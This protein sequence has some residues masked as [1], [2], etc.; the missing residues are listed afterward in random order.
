[1]MG[2][3]PLTRGKLSRRAR[4]LLS[5][6][7][8]PAH[9]GKTPHASRSP[10]RAAAHPRS[11]GENS[12][13]FKTSSCNAGSSPLT[14]GKPGHSPGSPRRCRLIP[15]HAGKTHPQYSKAR[16]QPGSSPLTRGKPCGQIPQQE[17]AGLIPAHAG[18]TTPGDRTRLCHRAHPRSRGENE[19]TVDKEIESKGS[20]P[21]TRGKP[22]CVALAGR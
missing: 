7:L 2:S 1:M 14:R 15:A 5:P 3:S 22:G 4:R 13:V 18:K 10:E 11:R 9:A 20:S 6:G 12:S 21:L 8:I 17:N 19:G 16:R